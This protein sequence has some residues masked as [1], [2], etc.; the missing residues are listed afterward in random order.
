METMPPRKQKERTEEKKTLNKK[1]IGLENEVT[2]CQ[3]APV[4][5]RKKTWYSR[6]VDN[7]RQ[8]AGQGWSWEAG[9]KDDC[10]CSI[11]VSAHRC[12]RSIATMP[13]TWPQEG[14]TQGK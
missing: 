8:I 6:V 1:D 13:G 4:S 11:C 14:V 9:R 3:A 7:S 5:S 2:C 10:A 12:I